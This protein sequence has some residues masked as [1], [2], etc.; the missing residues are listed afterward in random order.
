[1]PD[2]AA[3]IRA[4]WDAGQRGDLLP[5]RPADPAAAAIHRERA[6]IHRELAALEEHLAQL[7]ET[8]G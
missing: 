6:A 3:I 4:A 2:P 8:G 5:P 1:M 7:E